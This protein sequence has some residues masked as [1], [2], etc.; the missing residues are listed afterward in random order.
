MQGLCQSRLSTADYA[1]FL[2]V[3]ATTAVYSLEWS[4]AWPPPSL[5]NWASQSQSQSY[6]ATDGQSVCL[7]EHA[8]HTY[9][10][11]GTSH[12]EM[13][14][15][16]PALTTAVPKINGFRSA[17]RQK[18]K[19]QASDTLASKNDRPDLSSERAPHM[20]KGVTFI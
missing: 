2:V 6:V 1:L 17:Q 11:V 8:S 7:S 5:Y 14:A 16:K 19:N 15:T 12:I 4:Y 20:V 3:F 18:Y 10:Y 13:S 9:T